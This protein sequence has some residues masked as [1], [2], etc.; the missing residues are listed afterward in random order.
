M[1]H[2][3]CTNMT[4]VSTCNS[5]L[6]TVSPALAL[7]YKPMRCYYRFR[8]TKPQ[9]KDD[10]VIVVRFKS[11]KIGR[12]VNATDCDNGYLKV[13]KGIGVIVRPQG[14]EWNKGNKDTSR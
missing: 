2:A 1:Y 9:L 8:V 14:Y 7:R 12:V 5:I 4:F 13:M 11:F 3:V 6:V 10:W